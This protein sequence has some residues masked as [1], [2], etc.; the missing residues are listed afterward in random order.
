MGASYTDNKI[1]G[2]GERARRQRG[3][4]SQMKK[5]KERIRGSENKNIR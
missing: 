2:I 5:P 4:E 3:N 1:N